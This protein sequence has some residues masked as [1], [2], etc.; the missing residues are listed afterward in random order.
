M[1]IPDKIY[2]EYSFD[3]GFVN[4]EEIYNHYCSLGL[5]FILLTEY[6]NIHSFV[7]YYDYFNTRGIRLILGCEVYISDIIFNRKIKANV[8]L[9]V[10]NYKGYISLCNI[11]NKAWFRYSKLG[12]LYIKLHDLYYNRN[13]YVLSGG[14][15]GIYSSYTSNIS[16]CSKLTFFLKVHISNFFIEIQRN[17][18]Y[19]F[20]ESLFLLELSKLTNTNLIATF[21]VRYQSRSDFSTFCY[22]NYITR[23]KYFF[24]HKK[25]LYYYK[26]SY[27]LCNNDKYSLFIDCISR[28]YDISLVFKKCSLNLH[29]LREHLP[30]YQLNISNLKLFRYLRANIRYFDFLNSKE[31]IYRFRSELK[32]IIDT[33]FAFYFLLARNIV[34]WAKLK[35]IQVGPGRGS[36][37]SSLISFIFGITDIDPIRHKLIFERFLNKSKKSIPDFD[38]DFCKRQRDIVTNFVRLQFLNSNVTNI[39][40]F[41]KFLC[42]NTIRDLSRIIGYSYSFSTSLINYI[43]IGKEDSI[44]DVNMKNILLLSK[45]LEG[46]VKC[47][48]THAGGIIVSSKVIPICF[49]DTTRKHS[50]IQYDKDSISL[51]GMVKMDILGLNTLTILSDILKLTSLNISFRNIDITKTSVFNL[52]SSGNTTGIFQ[53]EGIGIRNFILKRGVTCFNELVNI[54]SIYRPGP[55]KFL[56]NY[57][58]RSKRLLNIRYVCDILRDTNGIILF[59]E[60]VIDIAKKVAGYSTNEADIFRTIISKGIGDDISKVRDRFISSCTD[61]CFNDASFLFNELKGM[62][63]YS[64]NRAHAVSYSYITYFMAFLKCYYKIYFYISLLNN[65]C[66]F[67][68]KMELLFLDIY[69]NKLSI[70]SPNIN[71]SIDTFSISSKSILFGFNGLR[72]L[73]NNVIISILKERSNCNFTSIYNF[74]SRLSVSKLS[75]R[76]L[77]II[78]YSGSLNSLEANNALCYLKFKLSI[79]NRSNL[80][81]SILTRKQVSNLHS[82]ILKSRNI[83]KFIY[84]ERYILGTNFTNVNNIFLLLEYRIGKLIT[85]RYTRFLY[86]YVGFLVQKKKNINSKY[87]SFFLKKHGFKTRCFLSQSS[88]L[89]KLLKINNILCFVVLNIPSYKLFIIKYYYV[90]YGK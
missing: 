61:I 26:N 40:T 59:Q 7:S 56:R 77:E 69:I 78:Y 50:L 16:F 36:C 49:L 9:I 55:L 52:I 4:K 44:T 10:K 19:S 14:Y 75:K 89:F 63:G 90:L 84:M 22:K 81:L 33:G 67:P 8:T 41:S 64:F 85:L 51:L 70:L 17:N 76:S 46:R 6:F 5:G 38:I 72:G 3:K 65:N 31:Y 54:I 68:N 37:S 15:K 39:V 21:P 60:Q 71:T 42:R 74:V 86:I 62:S 24:K 25:E 1:L 66:R 12:K 28:I 32:T 48:G 20:K 23:R 58:S 34:R 2:S 47:I 35:A 80:G 18:I 57:S 87:Y 45:K 88:S 82:S 13:I 79:L 29:K 27:F 53:I 30:I 11:L 83:Y 43:S 73:G